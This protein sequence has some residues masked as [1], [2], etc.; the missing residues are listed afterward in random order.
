[1]LLNAGVRQHNTPDIRPAAQHRP[2]GTVFVSILLVDIG[3]H[4]SLVAAP[5]SEAFL[6]HQAFAYLDEAYLPLLA[7]HNCMRRLG[8][9]SKA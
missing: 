2:P 7:H 6:S 3:S 9:D 4:W 5:S 1:M 8:G